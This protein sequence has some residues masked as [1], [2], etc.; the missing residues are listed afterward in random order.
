M[1]LL[2][3]LFYS[4]L[5]KD[6]TESLNTLSVDGHD[7]KN[8]IQIEIIQDRKEAYFYLKLYFN[9]KADNRFKVGF[10]N[11]YKKIPLTDYEK[12]I[13]PLIDDLINETKND[14]NLRIVVNEQFNLIEIMNLIRRD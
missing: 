5:L 8:S 4:V 11:A 7:V 2:Q 14:R 3:T 13:K 1:K 12:T 10:H 9:N 6:N